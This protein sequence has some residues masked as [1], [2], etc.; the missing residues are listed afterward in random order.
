VQCQKCQA[1]TSCV[2]AISGGKYY[3][4][5]C[6]GCLGGSGLS[7]GAQSHERRRQYEDYAQDTVQPYDAG[8]NPRPEFY[9]LYPDQAE[10]VFT[11]SEIEQVKTKL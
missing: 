6:H 3:K 1:K 10:K 4:S 7:S 5:I 9:R 2:S 11:R 8:G